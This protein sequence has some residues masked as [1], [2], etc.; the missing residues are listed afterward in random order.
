MSTGR[1]P[2]VHLTE[3]QLQD[4][5]AKLRAGRSKKS[6]AEEFGVTRFAIQYQAK[7]MEDC[8]V[9]N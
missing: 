3:D 8:N 9:N 1:K 4:L 5:R 2:T 6:L 7:R